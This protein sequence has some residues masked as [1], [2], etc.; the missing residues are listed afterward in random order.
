MFDFINQLDRSVV[1]IAIVVVAGIIFW[2][3]RRLMRRGNELKVYNEMLTKKMAG[4][5]ALAKA[6]R[7]ATN[8]EQLSAYREVNS[9]AHALLEIVDDSA[10]DALMD[11]IVATDKKTGRP[12]KAEFIETCDKCMKALNEELYHKPPKFR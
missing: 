4:Y 9:Q 3:S 6:C 2:L 10:K 8:S 7:T 12:N 5:S 1:I 11:L